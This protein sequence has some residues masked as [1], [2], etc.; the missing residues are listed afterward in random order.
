MWQRQEKSK[1]AAAK[2]RKK[3]KDKML[4]WLMTLW[5]CL[6]EQKLHFKACEET[7]CKDEKEQGSQ[8]NLSLPLM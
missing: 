8:G 6:N 3:P 1:T 2:D 5:K 7:E 4:E